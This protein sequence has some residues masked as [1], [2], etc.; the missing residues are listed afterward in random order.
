[1]SLILIAWHQ[2]SSVSKDESSSTAYSNTAPWFKL[3][4]RA[5]SRLLVPWQ[6]SV[7]YSQF[8]LTETDCRLPE[9]SVP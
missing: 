3:A 8:A 6:K 4:L 7:T 1:M 2:L 9:D 5:F